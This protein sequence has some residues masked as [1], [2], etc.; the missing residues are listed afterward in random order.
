VPEE[1]DLTGPEIMSQ[2]SRE[3][4]RFYKKFG[5]RDPA[6]SAHDFRK[7]YLALFLDIRRWTAN[8][9]QLP[10]KRRTKG[11]KLFVPSQ[12]RPRLLTELKDVANILD[13]IAKQRLTGKAKRG[14]PRKRTEISSGA[15]EAILGPSSVRKALFA[16]L[17][18]RGSEMLADGD[19]E[20]AV[21]W[22]H[23]DPH[24][25][26][27]LIKRASAQMARD[28]SIVGYGLVSCTRF[29]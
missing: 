7:A 24:I 15:C 11:N 25:D 2:L 26:T 23:D 19:F 17:R 22:G 5:T 6:R 18:E 3:A 27:I 12:E 4:E 8:R 10:K 20:E 13:T 28:P 21:I 16:P 9:P 1:Q 14:R 29:C